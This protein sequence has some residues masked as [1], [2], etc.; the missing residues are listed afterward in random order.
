M[1]LFDFYFFSGHVFFAICILL[2]NVYTPKH[3]KARF[4]CVVVSGGGNAMYVCSV[5]SC[6][7]FEV[8]KE[9]L[10]KKLLKMCF[11]KWNAKVC[12]CRK[13]RGKIHLARKFHFSE[14]NWASKLR[15]ETLADLRALP[16]FCFQ[17]PD[18]VRPSVPFIGHSHTFMC[19][20]EARRVELPS[21]AAFMHAQICRSPQTLLCSKQ[22]F[23]LI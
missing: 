13:R 21:R 17:L 8:L 15:M 7:L 4:L 16:V 22:F 6:H 19:S 1:T 20:V 10:K 14:G 2:L 12:W 5:F 9:V 18:P 11:C 3:F 23:S